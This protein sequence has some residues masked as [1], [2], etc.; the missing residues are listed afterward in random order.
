[1]TQVSIDN[2]VVAITLA[3]GESLTPNT[4]EILDIEVASNNAPIEINGL[5]VTNKEPNTFSTI[6]TDTDTIT[7]PSGFSGAAHIGGFDVS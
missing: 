6:L 7:N 3:P 4:G 1:M 2:T 5:K